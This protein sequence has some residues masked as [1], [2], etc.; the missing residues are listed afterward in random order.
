MEARLPRCHTYHTFSEGSF[1]EVSFRL[2]EKFFEDVEYF[3]GVT[4]FE[5]NEIWYSEESNPSLLDSITAAGD[6]H[7][8]KPLIGEMPDPPLGGNWTSAPHL[9]GFSA[10][11]KRSAGPTDR[12][13]RSTYGLNQVK[14]TF[15]PLNNN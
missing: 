1:I 7:S 10:R 4:Q 11:A 14:L 13:S 2:L 9:A 15:N 12:Q 6:I 5:W 8:T 3:F